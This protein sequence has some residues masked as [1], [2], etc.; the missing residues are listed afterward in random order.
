MNK[1]MAAEFT[2]TREALAR[3]ER[4]SLTITFPELNAHGVGEFFMLIEIA[5]TLAG[6]LYHVNPF[7]QPG[8]EHGKLLTYALMGR[9]GY[10][11]KAK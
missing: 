1:L 8:V 3:Q 6:H 5:T 7:D 11:D 9:K 10:E 2:A 4:P